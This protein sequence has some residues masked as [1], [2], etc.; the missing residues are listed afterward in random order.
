MKRQPSGTPIGGQFAEDRRPNG[1]DLPVDTTPRYEIK[2]RNKVDGEGIWCYFDED[3]M[4][5]G[6]WKDADEIEAAKYISSDDV[7]GAVTIELGAGYQIIVQSADLDINPIKKNDAFANPDFGVRDSDDTELI[8]GNVRVTLDDIGEGWNGDYNED[9]PDDE[10]LF[11]FTTYTRESADSEW[12]EVND[13]SYCTQLPTDLPAP[14]VRVALNALMDE[15]YSPLA[16][17]REA[18]V[19]G[20]AEKMSWIKPDDLKYHTL[21][22]ESKEAVAAYKTA[23]LWASTDDDEEPLDANHSPDEISDESNAQIEQN[24]MQFWERAKAEG[25]VNGVTPEQFGHDFFLTQNGHG[26]GFWDRGRGYAGDRLSEMAKVYGS[27]T[28]II[29]DDGKIYFE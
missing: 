2:V 18:S 10:S 11:R 12:E 17:D 9:D 24:V 5:E 3:D 1:G 22:I 26:A 19:T 29:G 23:A 25:L 20:A 16:N 8:R 15:F 28:P 27:T 7:N 21:A 14:Q 13:A 6:E 4:N